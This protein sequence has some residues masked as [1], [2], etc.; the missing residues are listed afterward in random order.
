MDDGHLWHKDCLRYVDDNEGVISPKW[1]WRQ[2]SGSNI[3]SVSATEQGCRM[4]QSKSSIQNVNVH[5]NE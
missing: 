3:L 2:R 5:K 1:S 4:L